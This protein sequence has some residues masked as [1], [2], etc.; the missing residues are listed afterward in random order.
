MRSRWRGTAAVS[1]T[2][3]LF[4]GLVAIITIVTGL[5]GV[6][7]LVSAHQAL[8]QAA[9]AAVTSESQ[10]GCWVA[11]T[12]AAVEKTILGD[13]INPAQVTV[14]GVPT[15]PQAYSTALGVQLSTVVHPIWWAGAGL[16]LTVMAH[17]VVQTTASSGTDATVVCLSAPTL[18]AGP[19]NT[20]TNDAGDVAPTL[21]CVAPDSLI[22]GETAT[23]YGD[24]F[25]ANVGALLL[26]DAGESW[27]SA[28]NAQMTVK[29]WEAG[30]FTPPCLTGANAGVATSSI[31]FTVPSPALAGTATLQVVLPSGALSIPFS[32]P[33][34]SS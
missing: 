31:Q 30:T 15:S 24:N 6:G 4:A 20:V 29:A 5:L 13:G 21:L 32:I 27:G 17:A 18:S 25:G 10:N 3:G 12:T 34:S 11:A 16:P 26:T 2:L 22:P 8:S 19:T 33:V 14:T 9:N 28:D 1:D 23:L 7:Q